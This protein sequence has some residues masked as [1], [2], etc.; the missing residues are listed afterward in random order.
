MST[1]TADQG[2]NDAQKDKNEAQ[3]EK[4]GAKID[5]AK[6]SMKE[7]VANAKIKGEEKLGEWEASAETES[8][9]LKQQAGE[10]SAGAG[11]VRVPGEWTD[12]VS[13]ALVGPPRDR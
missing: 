13:R 10:P 2:K 1:E 4:W 9:K 11:G 3:K 7:G 5:E 8:E 6:A 12:P